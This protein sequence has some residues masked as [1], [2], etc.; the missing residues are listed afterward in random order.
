MPDHVDIMVC[1]T[2]SFAARVVCDLAAVAP[3]PII[4]A[5]LG[6]N[7]S[8]LDWLR[9]AGN[10]RAHLYG[11]PATFVARRIDLLETDTLARV[12]EAA[13]PRVLVQAASS[14]PSAVISGRGD[15][16]S[17]LVADGGLSATAV[18]QAR[19]SL[20]V[21]RVLRTGA[22]DCYFINSCFPDVVNSMIA[23]A[24][25]PITCGVGNIG[26]LAN[27]FAG[28]LDPGARSSLR[29]LAHYQALGTWRRPPE[30]RSGPAP[31]VWLESGEI[32]DVFQRFATVQLTLEPAIEISGASG[33]PLMLAMAERSE[34]R[35]HVPGP[36][37]LPGG[38]PVVFRDNAL[39]LDL[40]PGLSEA[41]AIGWNASFEQ[42][43]GMVVQSNGRVRYTGKLYEKIRAESL[44][45]AEGFEL[46]DLEVVYDAMVALRARL[47]RQ[48]A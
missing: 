40:P 35:G 47:Q 41:E 2:G 21:A 18:F 36:N 23:A 42:R 44:L 28:S 29:L 31:R 12:L 45:L 27:A 32:D 9:T 20:R 8:R 24:G 3:R 30:E 7:L 48:S 46:D 25:L 5:I 10:A 39:T 43:S 16:W 26:I 1:G 14:Q 19:L 11:R 6:R 34:W 22:P 17:R 13:R 33:V 37:G 4:V 15:G 38:Y